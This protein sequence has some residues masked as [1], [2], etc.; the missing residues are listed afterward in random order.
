MDVAVPDEAR[1]IRFID[2][3]LQSF[4]LADE[5]AAHVDVTG[6]RAHREGGKQRAF[7]Q[8]VWIV[9]QDLAIFARTRFALVGVDDEIARPRVGLGHERPLE[10]RW[11]S[12]TTASA[13]AR[14]FDLVDD[15]VVTLV[16]EE[17]RAV[18]AA[19]RNRALQPHIVEAVN[20][21]ED[22]VAIMEH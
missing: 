6:V 19:A 22:A 10:A 11:K 3:A 4:A 8:Q 1:G 16:D 15:P 13:Q 18:P 5:F 21:A 14:S 7:D 17:F 9:A 2:R 20:V 12:S